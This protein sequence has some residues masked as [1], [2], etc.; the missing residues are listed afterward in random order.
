M[1]TS[2]VS[3][4][5]RE[6]LDHPVL[7]ADGHTIEYLPA[8]VDYFRAEGIEIDLDEVSRFSAPYPRPVDTRPVDTGPV[9]TRVV[10]TRPAGVLAR[11][12]GLLTLRQANAWYRQSEEERRR[13]R[14]VRPAFWGVPT[15]HPADLASVCF[16]KL[17]YA[18][19]DEFGLD[20]AIVYPTAALGY[21]HLADSD[22]SRAACRAVNAY[23]RDVFADY[24][25]RLIPV[26]AIPM[27]T[28]DQAVAD[29]DHAVQTLGFKA[30]VIPSYVTRT[31]PEAGD[32]GPWLDTYGLDSSY[33]YDSFWARCVDLGVS[34]ATHSP[35]IGLG[36]R[37]SPSNFMYNRIGHFAASGEALAKA[38]FL[39]GVTRRFPH[40]R[41]AFLEGGVGL[42]LSLYCELV[43]HWSKRNVGAIDQYDP[44]N[45]DPDVFAELA[46]TWGPQPVRRTVAVAKLGPA[47]HPLGYYEQDRAHRDDF[48]ALGITDVEQV[49]DLFVPNFYFG[50][51]GDDPMTIGAFTNPAIP[52]GARLNTMFSSDIGHWDVPD[53]TAVLEGV[54]EPFEHGWLTAADVRDLAFANAAR[55]YLESNPAFFQ[56][57]VLES[58][59]ATL[60][61]ANPPVATSRA[62]R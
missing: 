24:L 9:D 54:W 42:G 33:D 18:R 43:S 34:P 58:E 12:S 11:P 32:A 30:V 38:L 50:C 3:A 27:A 49:R 59:V 8:L 40:L 60:C 44:A 26:A 17:H 37:R 15:R 21:L 5:V 10:D 35:F 39:G 7:D 62:Q 52:L 4:L 31:G 28:P 22:L 20:A 36:P 23:H 19:L 57:T 29:L 51:E 46:T 1:P 13:K 55:F 45:L 47:G 61:A 48:A 25:D 41:V 16:P 6:K 14:T 56:G 53:V 2:S